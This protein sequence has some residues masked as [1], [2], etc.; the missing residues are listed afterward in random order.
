MRARVIIYRG[1]GK[2]IELI[3]G[4]FLSAFYFIPK[5]L[6]DKCPAEIQNFPRRPRDLLYDEKAIEIANSDLFLLAM[7]DT[8]AYLVWP[9]LGIPGE[10]ESYSG[11]DP[12]WRIAH[13]TSYWAEA[14]MEEKLIPTVQSLFKELYWVRLG[15]VSMEEATEILAQAVPAALQK[16]GLTAVL[17]TVKE[18]R[19]EEDFDYRASHQKTDYY[20]KQYHT[21]SKHPQCSLEELQEKYIEQYDGEEFDVPDPGDAMEEQSNS[22]TDIDQFL[23]SLSERDRRIVEGRLNGE[24]MEEI[25]QRVG[26]KTHSAVWKRL[27]KIGSIYKERNQ[28]SI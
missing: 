23:A 3:Y 9:H 25:A 14:M 8:L 5:C 21:R 2:K 16:H 10:M 27:E 1:D 6:L 20:R 28:D 18:M 7:I 15:Y 22:Q 4:G 26:Y 17:E 12:G 24:T 13:C 11:Y 19:C